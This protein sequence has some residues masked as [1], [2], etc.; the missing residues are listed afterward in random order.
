MSDTGVIFI[1]ILSYFVAA[2]PVAQ[3]AWVGLL[4]SEQERQRLLPPLPRAAWEAVQVNLSK[5]GL[6][7][8]D[9]SVQWA[10]WAGHI[11]PSCFTPKQCCPEERHGRHCPRCQRGHL[12]SPEPTKLAGT[13]DGQIGVAQ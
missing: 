3:S 12:P 11:E 7:R 5:S 9:L 10:V 1:I 13:A 4:V 8:T 6:S 2:W